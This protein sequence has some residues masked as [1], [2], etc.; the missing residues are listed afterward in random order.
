MSNENFLSRFSHP[1]HLLPHTHHSSRRSKDD[2]TQNTI[3]NNKLQGCEGGEDTK[4]LKISFHM[5]ETHGNRQVICCIQIQCWEDGNDRRLNEDDGSRWVDSIFNL[6][7]YLVCMFLPL[8]I[9]IR[10]SSLHKTTNNDECRNVAKFLNFKFSLFNIWWVSPG[11]QEME[12]NQKISWILRRFPCKIKF[13]MKMFESS[14]AI[15]P[16]QTMGKVEEMNIIKYLFS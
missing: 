12:L 2:E 3:E 16:M 7:L 14:I 13:S 10:F 15:N 4:Q 9:D 1:Q 8:W 5:K 11:T 6:N